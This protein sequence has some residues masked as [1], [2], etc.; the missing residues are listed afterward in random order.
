M[1]LGQGA[2]ELLRP[3]DY[4]RG[5]RCE[6][7]SVQKKLEWIVSGV[8]TGKKRQNVC[9]FVLTEPEEV[10]E[11]IQTCWDNETSVSKIN[12]FSQSKNELL[13]QKITESTTNSQVSGTKCKCGV[14]PS[15]N[16][17]TTTAQPW[18]SVTD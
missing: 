5:T 12:Y 17:R 8:L 9:Q 1:I 6:P 7:F 3:L 13:A 18:V 14:N 4:I 15:Q 16:C 2:Y 11:N 10:A